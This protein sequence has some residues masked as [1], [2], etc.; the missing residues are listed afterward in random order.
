M[1][2]VCGKPVRQ[3]LG[4]SASGGIADTDNYSSSSRKSLKAKYYF[5]GWIILAFSFVLNVSIGPLV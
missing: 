4:S 5:V 2:V 1:V 3:N